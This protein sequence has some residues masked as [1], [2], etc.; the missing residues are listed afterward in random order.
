MIFPYFLLSMFAVAQA[1]SG[2]LERDG[3]VTRVPC[4]FSVVEFIPA[5]Q[6]GQGCTFARVEVNPSELLDP[7]QSDPQVVLLTK[8]QMVAGRPVCRAQALGGGL[9]GYV[10]EANQGQTKFQMITRL[11]TNTHSANQV[12]PLHF[13]RQTTIEIPRP[14]RPPR[15]VIEQRGC[16]VQEDL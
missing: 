7:S 16:V 4:H 5:D 3:I 12:L 13:S 10:F 6:V 8:V 9:P 14:H 1:H 15:R 11:R 2:F